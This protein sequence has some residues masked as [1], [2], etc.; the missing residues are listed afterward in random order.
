M[1]ARAAFGTGVATVL[2]ASQTRFLRSELIDIP[3]VTVNPEV[4]MW[5]LGFGIVLAL[6]S[7]AIPLM[8]L[9]RLDPAAS[10]A[11]Q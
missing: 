10:L 1:S 4:W 8:K 7:S 6:V 5:A 11:S 2:T 9:R 3:K